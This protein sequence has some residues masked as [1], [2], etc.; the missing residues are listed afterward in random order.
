MGRIVVNKS[1]TLLPFIGGD[2]DDEEE[3]AEEGDEATR[4]HSTFCWRHSPA[5]SIANGQMLDA[6]LDTNS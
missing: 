6:G 1:D 4:E 3:D 2:E 5:T